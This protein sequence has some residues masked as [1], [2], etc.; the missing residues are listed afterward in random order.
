MEDVNEDSEIDALPDSVLIAGSQALLEP[1]DIN[2]LVIARWVPAEIS[3]QETV[4]GSCMQSLASGVFECFWLPLTAESNNRSW[5]VYVGN[6]RI[7]QMI[8]DMQSFIGRAFQCYYIDQGRYPVGSIGFS[9]DSTEISDHLF[10]DGSTWPCYEHTL[11]LSG[12]KYFA[13]LDV[14]ITS[15]LGFSPKDVVEH[16][17]VTDDLMAQHLAL[18]AFE[19]AF[20]DSTLNNRDQIRSKLRE[21]S[22]L[23]RPIAGI[24]EYCMNLDLEERPAGRWNELHGLLWNL[25]TEMEGLFIS[26]W[27]TSIEPIRG[28]YEAVLA[29]LDVL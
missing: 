17:L 25:V 18:A 11:T 9:L 6:L 4:V 14:W 3:F 5:G 10:G 27:L 23:L 15:Q 20:N 12:K 2:D 19:S 26:E 22:D 16:P 8:L 21:L 29:Q 28:N 1:A 24:V 13:N 7:G